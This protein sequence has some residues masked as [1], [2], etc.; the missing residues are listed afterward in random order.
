MNIRVRVFGSLVKEI[1]REHHLDLDE[2]AKMRD[3]IQII[4]RISN[5][6]RSGYLGEYRVNGGDLAIIVNGRNIALLDEMDTAL[7][8]GDDVV[9]IPPTAGG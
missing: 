2:D 9:I 6:N 1:G 7:S 5:Q 3:I 4:S 8:D